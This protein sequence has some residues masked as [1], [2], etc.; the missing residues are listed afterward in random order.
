MA[1]AWCINA[2]SCDWCLIQTLQNLDSSNIWVW[3]QY[4]APDPLGDKRLD[5]IKYTDK[6]GCTCCLTNENEILIYATQWVIKT[7]TL[8]N[9][10]TN[11]KVIVKRSEIFWSNRTKTIV[12]YKTWWYPTSIT[13]WTLAVQETTQNQYSTNWYGVSWLTSWTQ[14]YFTAFAVDWNNN[15]IDLKNATITPEFWRRIIN[16]IS[17]A[18]KT[19]YHWSQEQEAQWMCRKP[20]WKKFYLVWEWWK[21]C[22]QYSCSTARDISTA[23]Y[24]NKSFSLTSQWNVPNDIR[25]NDSWTKLYISQ[26]Q[27]AYKYVC[28][29]TLSTARD[30]STATYDNVHSFQANWELMSFAFW[31]KWAYLYLL[32][33]SSNITRYTLTAPYDITSYTATQTY[34]VPNGN[35]NWLTLNA[36]WTQL[37]FNDRGNTKIYCVNLNTARSLLSIWTTKTFS[38]NYWWDY[39]VLSIWDKWK[40]LYYWARTWSWTPSA[41]QRTIYQY[42]TT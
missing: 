39:M 32:T 5:Y 7:L 30:I 3:V 11:E 22:Y 4:T 12:R 42:T 34:N 14:Y 21:K 17:Y 2:I 33:R 6:C 15:L 27:S 18:N 40:K 23:T 20:D 31:N 29:Y 19:F 13:D 38:P 25:I 36:Q 24:D 9:D 8:T 35:C 37:F 26:Y 1:N 10:D 16:W 41:S 28:Q